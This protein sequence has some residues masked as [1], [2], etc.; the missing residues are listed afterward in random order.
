[1]AETGQVAHILDHVPRGCSPII[2]DSSS[3]GQ[4][5]ETTTGFAGSSSIII[6]I[7]SAVHIHG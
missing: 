3:D 6:G 4:R 5:G 7:S 2:E 1:M